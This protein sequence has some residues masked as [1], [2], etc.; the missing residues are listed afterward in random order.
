M[1]DSKKPGV[2]FWATVVVVV[3]LLYPISFG[4]ACWITSR[5]TSAARWLPGFYWPILW[6]MAKNG[7][8]YRPLNG[9]AEFGAAENWH[10]V[11]VSDSATRDHSFVW[12]YLA[13]GSGM[14]MFS[15]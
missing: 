2:A 8:V 7:G 10:W 9:Y 5:T 6:G 1:T 13:P 12:M 14:G 4:P 3:V 11:D 15:L